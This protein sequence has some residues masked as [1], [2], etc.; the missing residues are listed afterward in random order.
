MDATRRGFLAAAAYVRVPGANSRPRIGVIGTGPR[1]SY[2]MGE[3]MRA[4]DVEVAAVC[5][6]Y[7]ARREKARAQAGPQAQAYADYR[8][9]LERPD[10][11]GVIVA[12]PDHWHAAITVD[13][14]KA[15]KDVY[16]EK[17]MVHYPKD[18][19]AIVRAARQY[20]RVVQVGM[21]AAACSS[22]RPPSRSMWMAE[23]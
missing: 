12:T 5:D 17:P 3:A 18:G 22:F 10:L 15:G 8:A 21:Q 4:L 7:D 19:Q 14:C 23:S 13:A 9:V 20:K 6:V 11:D 16:V 1:G 2:L